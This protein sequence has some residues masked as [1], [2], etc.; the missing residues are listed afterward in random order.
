MK[1]NSIKKEHKGSSDV[2]KIICKSCTAKCDMTYEFQTGQVAGNKCPRGEVYAKRYRPD[3]VKIRTYQLPVKNGHMKRLAVRT[4][5]P[6]SEDL[7]GVIEAELKSVALTAPIEAGEAVLTNVGG[8]GVAL[9]ATR[10]MP[11]R[12]S[13]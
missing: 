1:L 9:V 5:S 2:Q 8:T 3:A 10:K 11:A 4:D 13:V 7:S 6:I 12:H